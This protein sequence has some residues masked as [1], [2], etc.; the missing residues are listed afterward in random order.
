MN[1]HKARYSN[2][3]ANIIVII[4]LQNEVIT[5]HFWIKK[6]LSNIIQKCWR[7]NHIVR[8][9]DTFVMLFLKLYFSCFSCR[10]QKRNTSSR[11]WER[12]SLGRR[13]EKRTSR[14]CK[15]SLKQLTQLQSWGEL[16]K[17]FPRRS[18]HR[19]EKRKNQYVSSHTVQSIFLKEEIRCTFVQMNKL[20]QFYTASTPHGDNPIC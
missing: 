19:R 6:P 7:I 2:L 13:S 17:E 9:N 1:A 12:L 16:K 18:F 15:N 20:K 8:N 10:W 11:S 3:Y 5:F 14:I 4:K